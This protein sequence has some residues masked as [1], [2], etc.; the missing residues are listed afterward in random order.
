[1]KTIKIAAFAVISALT[2]S[3]PALAATA[4]ADLGV[5][6]TLANHCKVTGDTIDFGTVTTLLD[7]N[8]D[9]IDASGTI[10]V[11]CTKG[12]TYSLSLDAGKGVGATTSARKMTKG[13][14]SATAPTIGYTLALGSYSGVGA[15]G[16][17]EEVTVDANVPSQDTPE[18]GT[19]TD[20]VLITVTY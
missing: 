1:M 3:G 19:Y 20:T 12:A 4:T 13:T 2:A 11:K 16:P 6:L 8:P 15:T 5:T 10:S 17:A 18:A 7:D 9:G 14:P